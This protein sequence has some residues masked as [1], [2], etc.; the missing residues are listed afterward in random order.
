[1][2]AFGYPVALDLCGRPC[3]VIGG[4]PVAAR[5]VEGLLAAGARVTVVSPALSDPLLA[6]ARDGLVAWRPR[7]YAPGDLEGARLCLAATG[8]PAVDAAVAAEGR[9]RGVLVNAA[10][11]PERCD[12]I[13]PS[14]ARRGPLTVAVST[15]GASPFMARLVREAIEDFLDEGRAAL[16]EVVA[17]ARRQLQERGVALD[18]EGWRRAVNEDVRRLAAAGRLD[19]ARLRLGERLGV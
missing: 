1:V 7:E 4:G 12:F 2:G 10:D 11:D 6:L 14:V 5:K 8:D 15:G 16:V 3:M 9:E 13:L 18:A 19:E 17:E